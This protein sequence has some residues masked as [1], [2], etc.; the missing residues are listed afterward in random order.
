M[1]RFPAVVFSA[2]VALATVAGAQ[3]GATFRT[4]TNAVSVYATVV[5]RSGQLVSDLTQADFEV[6]DNGKRQDLTVFSS[7]VQSITIVVMLDRSGS[8]VEQF[9]LVSEAAAAFLD[10]LL[11]AD[12]VR[13]GS[14]SNRVQ[15]DPA[16][17]TSD[18]N[19][20]RR[21]LRV[22]L[23]PAGPTP[24][25]NATSAAL[26]A[27][28]QEQGRRV[29]LM[30]TDGRDN[31]DRPEASVSFPQIRD[32]VEREEA[33]V[34]A[35][36]LAGECAPAPKS[37]RG[38]SKGPLF[39]GRSRPGSGG[40]TGRVAP[41]PSPRLP[42]PGPRIGG[43]RVLPPLPGRVGGI[44]RSPLP[45]P[46]PGDIILG[47]R[48]PDPE[49]AITWSSGCAGGG[50]DPNLRELADHAGGGYFELTGTENLGATFA[51]IADEL[52][53]QYLLAFTPQALDG[54]VHTLEIR[55]R[56]PDLTVRGRRTYVASDQR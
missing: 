25:W 12:R 2:L 26:T 51:R 30:F 36:G 6:F 7:D 48:L 16:S 47:R 11:P 38:E 45:R 39:Q 21:I 22:D 3:Q 46:K 44:G 43:G 56:R 31:P 8:M 37:P 1:A 40:G 42:M 32:R 28:A 24:L 9:G 27:L 10:Q 35:I 17:F 4:G 29:V 13:L 49:G 15:I 53:H 23:Q 55:L 50:P 52:H 33:M 19:E 14:F 34:Y 54:K 41:R 20:L 18:A 5:D